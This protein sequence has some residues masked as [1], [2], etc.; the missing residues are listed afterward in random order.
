MPL[1]ASYQFLRC[2]APSRRLERLL[3]GKPHR[4]RAGKRRCHTAFAM[5]RI[6]KV[7]WWPKTRLSA[8]P[9]CRSDRSR[10]PAQRRL[11]QLS[12]SGSR[13]VDFELIGTP[14]VLLPKTYLSADSTTSSHIGELGKGPWRSDELT[15][16]SHWSVPT[17]FIAWA[18]IHL[19][20]WLFG[21]KDRTMIYISSVTSPLLDDK[22]R[23]AETATLAI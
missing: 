2:L 18:L 19:A 23:K 10:Y 20:T 9:R 5:G 17:T 21:N 16:V 7:G 14:T 4:I 12:R 1:P 13:R 22:V 6:A 8:M 11:C 3:P 15:A